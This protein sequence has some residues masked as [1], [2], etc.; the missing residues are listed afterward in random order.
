[1][2]A[3]NIP[4][5]ENPDFDFLTE[6]MI[7][8]YPR[9][10]EEV[11]RLNRQIQEV[12]EAFLEG[13]ILGLELR[14][15]ET[16]RHAHRV[17]ELSTEMAATMGIDESDIMYLRWGALLHDIGKIGVPDS[18]LLKPG[19]LTPEEWVTMRK[20]TTYAYEMLSRVS[21]LGPAIEI[22]VFHHEKWD[23]TGYPNGLKGE[24]IPLSARIFAVVD[25]WDALNSKRPYREEPWEKEKI[26]TLI[27]EQS[28]KHFDPAVVRVFLELVNR[29]A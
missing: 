8:K 28:G 24:Q 22:P 25:V 11:R 26:L 7:V 15:V 16:R 2:N 20:H 1:M 19:P 9:L 14:D 10:T 27:R 23:G 5:P 6:S 21:F 13:W 4:D 18:I 29:H 12:Y 17:T 3:A